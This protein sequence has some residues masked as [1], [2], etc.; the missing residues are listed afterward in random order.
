MEPNDEAELSLFI[1]YLV[2]KRI[3][4]V[5]STAMSLT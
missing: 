5:W 2:A 1:H 4:F 3:F